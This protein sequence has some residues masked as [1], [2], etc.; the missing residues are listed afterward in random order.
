MTSRLSSTRIKLEECKSWRRVACTRLL[1]FPSS[2][3]PLQ[4]QSRYIIFR[5]DIDTFPFFHFPFFFF[6]IDEKNFPH[7][8]ETFS[9]IH[10]STDFSVQRECKTLL[11]FLAKNEVG[12]SFFFP[13]SLPLPSKKR[14]SVRGVPPSWPGVRGS[15]LITNVFY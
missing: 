9:S 4:F 15:W 1:P 10:P 14:G 5:V 12:I 13:P 2:P 6:S 11:V 7:T 8:W 3:P